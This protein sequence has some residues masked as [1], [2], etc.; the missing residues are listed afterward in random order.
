MSTVRFEK[1]GSK[2]AVNFSYDPKLVEW[3]KSFPSWARGYDPPTK[4]WT[5]EPEYARRFAADMK[6][7]GHTVIGLDGG[8]QQQR[9][10]PPPPPPR[11][12]VQKQN[13]ADALFE[14]IPPEMH[15]S[16]YRALSRVLHADAGGDDAL[17]S[18]LNGARSKAQTN[19]NGQAAS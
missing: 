10:Q 14:R 7:N 1:R 15:T 12:I 11:Q 8:Q 5:L 3:I 16:V 4:T 19:R 17:Q 13:W 6:A 2:Y 9:R 18:E